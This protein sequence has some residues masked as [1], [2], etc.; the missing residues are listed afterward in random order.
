MS[1]VK[2]VYADFQKVDDDRR[3]IL[4]TRGTM[5]DLAFFGIELQDGLILTFYSDDA[6][7]SGN[8]DDLVVKGVVHYDRRSERWVAEINWNEIKHESEIRAD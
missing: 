1:N 2:R 7:D 6:D 3:L 4:T 5:R 8:K